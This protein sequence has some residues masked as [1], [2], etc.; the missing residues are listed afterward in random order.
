LQGATGHLRP[1]HHRP[2]ISSQLP[3]SIFSG[4]IHIPAI[5][6]TGTLITGDT[7]SFNKKTLQ[8]NISLTA[9]RRHGNS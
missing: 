5:F 4:S 2:A 3:A 8:P 1:H 7:V 9:P 6:Q